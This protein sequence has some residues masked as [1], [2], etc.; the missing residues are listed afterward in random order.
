MSTNTKTITEWH[1][2]K[3]RGYRSGRQQKEVVGQ[4]EPELN[5]S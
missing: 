2:M 5:Q 1:S 3:K 4:A